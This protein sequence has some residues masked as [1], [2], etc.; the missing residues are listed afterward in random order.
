MEYTGNRTQRTI[1]V[2]VVAHPLQGDLLVASY[3]GPARNYIWQV[4]LD[5]GKAYDCSFPSPC[6]QSNFERELFQDMQDA[7]SDYLDT[8]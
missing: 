3:N 1:K 5:D 4:M 7:A 2:E 8:L 6:S